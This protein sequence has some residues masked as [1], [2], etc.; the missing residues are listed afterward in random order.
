MAPISKIL[1]PRQKRADKAERAR[2]L[3]AGA[4]LR[5]ED[6]DDE[7]GT[8]EYP[9]EWTY[10]KQGKNGRE[11]G[12]GESADEEKTPR[13]RKARS[14]A[15]TQGE[16]IGASMGSF[17]CKIG[18]AVLLKAEGQSSAWVGIIYQF[19]EDEE[20]EKSANFL[21]FANEKEIRPQ[22]KDKKRSDFLPVCKIHSPISTKLMM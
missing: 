6:S 5:R 11:D 4:T 21:W 10:A 13:K 9:W 20:G 3:L 2:Q 12:D 17:K 19:L 1:T 16:I 15:R 14:A 7:L 22:L 8:D 18:D